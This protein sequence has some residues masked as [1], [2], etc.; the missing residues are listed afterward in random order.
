MFN[1]RLFSAR[2]IWMIPVGQ[3]VCIDILANSPIGPKRNNA[4]SP[5]AGKRFVSPLSGAGFDVPRPE[6]TGGIQA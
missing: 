2:R 1:L 6:I 3:M 5:G 4:H